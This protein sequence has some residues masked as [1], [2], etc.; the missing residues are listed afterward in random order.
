MRF[1]DRSMANMAFLFLV[2]PV[3]D[4]SPGL[5]RLLVVWDQF[6]FPNKLKATQ[7]SEYKS[8][9]TRPGRKEWRDQ[10]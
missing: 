7:E 6:M 4:P 2:S 5:T 10:A 9:R 8:G 1:S 3:S